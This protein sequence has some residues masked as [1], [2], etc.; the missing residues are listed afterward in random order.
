MALQTSN[1]HL[2]QVLRSLQGLLWAS[3][4]HSTNVRGIPR[5][6]TPLNSCSWEEPESP[7]VSACTTINTKYAITVDKLVITVPPAQ[8][9]SNLRKRRLAFLLTLIA[10]SSQCRYAMLIK[11]IQFQSWSILEPPW[12]SWTANYSSR[13]PPPPKESHAPCPWGSGQWTTCLLGTKHNPCHL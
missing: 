6:P 9:Y 3:L 8:K 11:P 13:G 4:S 2:I 5:P 1:T 12:T 10:F 7:R